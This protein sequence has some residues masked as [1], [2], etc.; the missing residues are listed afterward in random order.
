MPESAP[1]A[2][3]TITI[4]ATGSRARTDSV[5]VLF[6]GEVMSVIQALKAASLLVEPIKVIT[7]SIIIT[8]VTVAAIAAAGVVPIILATFSGEM[9][10]NAITVTPHII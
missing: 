4:A 1:K 3:V 6:S 9:S 5:F 2:T 8:T 10:A 7:Q